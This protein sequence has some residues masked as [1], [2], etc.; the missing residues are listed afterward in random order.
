MTKKNHGFPAIQTSM[1][2]DSHLEDPCGKGSP[3]GE[4]RPINGFAHV[5]SCKYSRCIRENG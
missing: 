3:A 2:E 4:K 5:V 1:V